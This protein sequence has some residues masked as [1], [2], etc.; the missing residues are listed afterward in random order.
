MI[1]QLG[2]LFSTAVSGLGSL[3]GGGAAPAASGGFLSTLGS[4]LSSFATETLVPTVLQGGTDILTGLAR[5]ELSRDARRAQEDALKAQVRQAINA[6]SPVVAI[7]QGPEFSG[8]SATGT[9]FI[10]PTILP[11]ATVPAN[12]QL[13]VNPN[14]FRPSP[15]GSPVATSTGNVVRVGGLGRVPVPGTLGPDMGFGQQIIEIPPGFFE[16][17]AN[18]GTTPMP[19]QQMNGVFRRFTRNREGTGSQLFVPNEN[20]QGPNMVPLEQ[21]RAFGIDPD[22]L[23][24]FRFDQVKGKFTKMKRR[25]MNPCNMRA[26]FRAGRRVDAME[27][28]ARKL[29]SERRREKTSPIRRKRRTRKKTRC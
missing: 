22:G 16:P 20:P 11:P 28:I 8:G 9:P 14:L 27:R 12:Q 13:K 5:R 26:F 29:F 18:G 6:I 23:P 10:P 15:S 25:R 1:L 4:T 7:G 2:T 17:S 19:T 24:R 3:F 21:A